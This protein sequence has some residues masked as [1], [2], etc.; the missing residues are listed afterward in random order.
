MLGPCIVTA[1]EIA[2]VY[3]LQMRA[4]VNGVLKTDGSTKSM[5]WDFA[6]MIAHLSQ[7]ETIYPG[8]VIGSGTVGDGCGFER[9]E[10]LA[11]G[12][13]VELEIQGI[14]RTANKIV[15]PHIKAGSVL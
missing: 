13:L 12:D 1:D 5:K 4:W 15:A 2:D 10:F 11:D 8:E 3:N 6:D 14:G 7:S 9:M